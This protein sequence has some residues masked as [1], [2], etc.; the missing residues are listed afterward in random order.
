[1]SLYWF[2]N[3]LRAKFPA[4]KKIYLFCWILNRARHRA[5]FNVVTARP[6]AEEG[7]NFFDVKCFLRENRNRSTMM[8]F[9]WRSLLHWHGQEKLFRVTVLFSVWEMCR[10]RSEEFSD[11]SEIRKLANISVSISHFHFQ[12]EREREM[13]GKFERAENL[14]C[15]GKSRASVWKICLFVSRRRVGERS[16]K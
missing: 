1:M 12:W 4:Q 16:S 2:C 5:I 6:R 8:L 14:L 11:E 10:H 3:L 7:K 15:I 13:F 9:V